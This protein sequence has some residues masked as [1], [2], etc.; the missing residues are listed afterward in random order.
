M[1]VCSCELFVLSKLVYDLYV[2][3]LYVYVLFVQMERY[4]LIVLL[5]AFEFVQVRL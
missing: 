1:D 4:V 2:R 3:C 5:D